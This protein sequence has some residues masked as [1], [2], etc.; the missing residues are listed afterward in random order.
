MNFKR[1][2]NTKMLISSV[3]VTLMVLAAE[4]FEEPE[5][6]FPEIAALTIGTLISKKMPWNTDYAR[7]FVLM[8][9]SAVIGYLLSITDAIPLY[10][11]IIFAFALCA[12]SL[13]I[14]RC[15]MLPMISACILPLLTSVRSIIYPISVILLT[16]AVITV[17]YILTKLGFINKQEYIKNEIDYRSE[18]LHWG[19][20]VAVLMA[21]SAVALVFQI[22][23]I[24][25]PPLIVAFAESSYAESPV[26][27]N[28]TGFFFAM[29]L[30]ALIGTM[31][32]LIFHEFAGL[33]LFV[34]VFIT[35]IAAFYLL[36]LLD[37]LF[38]P[39]AA[40]SVLPFIL[41]E[42]TLLF[43]VMEVIIGAVA[44]IAAAL[45]YTKVESGVLKLMQDK[46]PSSAESEHT[47]NKL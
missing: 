25:S 36:L 7:M 12:A 19:Y 30:C 17:R 41:S 14:S 10:P 3:I 8:S 33:S 9:I 13:I 35:V 24:I 6:I 16:A 26:R 45:A 18:I 47:N 28:P 44:L 15:T 37:K 4:L 38:P 40:L 23:F 11:K 20:L 27:K 42:D 46:Q 21:I 2:L 32:R 34:S 43:Y 39:A 5:I 22:P 31:G 29:A 1:K